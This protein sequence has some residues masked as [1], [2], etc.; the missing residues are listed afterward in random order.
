MRHRPWSTKNNARQEEFN[1][2][3]STASNIPFPDWCTCFTEP[4]DRRLVRS[5]HKFVE[6]KVVVGDLLGAIHCT[7][8]TL[9]DATRVEDSVAEEKAPR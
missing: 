7:R 1:F 2:Q 8:A 4:D 6:D 5:P 3:L 9:V